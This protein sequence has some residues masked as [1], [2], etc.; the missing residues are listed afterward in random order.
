MMEVVVTT[1]AVR[2]AKL[3][4]NLHYQQINIQLSAGWMPFLSRNQQCQS[5]EGKQNH[6]ENNDQI[7]IALHSC[8][9]T[10]NY[11]D[12]SSIYT[13]RLSLCQL[14][15]KSPVHNTAMN[16]SYLDAATETAVALR[17]VTSNKCKQKLTGKLVLL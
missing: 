11:D 7:S 10:G 2:R 8:N 5:T 1:G 9:F 17:V 13:I 16:T 15:N 12:H 3:Q 6:N 14:S 4:S